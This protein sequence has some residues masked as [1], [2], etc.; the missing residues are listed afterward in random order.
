MKNKEKDDI[1]GEEQSDLPVN[2]GGA[3]AVTI[4]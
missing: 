1:L 4:E 2:E 3:I